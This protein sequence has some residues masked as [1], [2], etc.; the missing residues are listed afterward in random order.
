MNLLN[1]VR[2]QRGAAARRRQHEQR[3]RIGERSEVLGVLITGADR[4]GRNAGPVNEL[5]ATI[6]SILVCATSTFF[7]PRW[8]SGT[9][10]RE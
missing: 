10:S 6:F 5:G 2:R 7:A 1:D 4:L 9:A 8:N 3:R